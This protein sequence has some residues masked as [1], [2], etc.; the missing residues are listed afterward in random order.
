LGLTP[1]DAGATIDS[2]GK[3]LRPQISDRPDDQ[4]RALQMVFQNPGGSLNRRHSVRRIIGRA[5]TRLIGLAGRA[6]EQR[7]LELA[8]SVRLDRALLALWPVQ[9]PGGGGPAGGRGSKG[10]RRTL[11]PR[12]PVAPCIV[13]AHG[14]SATYASKRNRHWPNRSPDTSS[15]AITRSRSCAGCS[16]PRRPRQP[17]RES[18][19]A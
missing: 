10:N 15:A 7:I 2:E 16:G 1:P 8:Q 12:R 6:R 9:L 14:S 11:Q 5:L 3:A 17:S 19:P 18:R 4:I 13:D